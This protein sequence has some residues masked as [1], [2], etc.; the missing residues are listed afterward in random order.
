MIIAVNPITFPLYYPIYS[1][2]DGL[3]DRIIDTRPNYNGGAVYLYKLDD[4]FKY[5]YMNCAYSTLVKP[6]KFYGVR[7]EPYR[8]FMNDLELEG[9]R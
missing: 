2:R 5:Q 1:N 4:S 6:K 9:F 7:E 3:I 8:F